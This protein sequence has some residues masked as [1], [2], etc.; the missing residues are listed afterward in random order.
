MYVAMATGQVLFQRFYYSKSFVR[1]PV[2][3][4]A[5][6]CITLAWKME[7]GQMEIRNVI[8]VFNH[9]KQFRNGDS[10]ILMGLFP[11]RVFDPVILDRN[12]VA[13]K[14]QNNPLIKTI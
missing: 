14:N 8:N 4:T 12:Y 2:E 6:A 3:I 13:L 10:G 7:V 5:M 9:M 1:C 11:F